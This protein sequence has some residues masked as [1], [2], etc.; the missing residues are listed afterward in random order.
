L[1]NLHHSDTPTPFELNRAAT[2]ALNS[3]RLTLQDQ[4]GLT[5]IRLNEL[6][7]VALSEDKTGS[8]R[9]GRA[10]QE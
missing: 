1:L 4:G 2:Q 6:R 9:M 7:P 10:G 3:H 5:A 8:Q